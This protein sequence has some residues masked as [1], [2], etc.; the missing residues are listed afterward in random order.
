M[1]GSK[2]DRNMSDTTTDINIFFCCF[3]PKFVVIGLMA[4]DLKAWQVGVR[5]RSGLPGISLTSASP[6]WGARVQVRACQR[7]GR[8]H[9]RS[10][11]GLGP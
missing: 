9:A 4:L 5:A 11:R 8:L 2:A 7:Y 1:P 3:A 10:V 6:L